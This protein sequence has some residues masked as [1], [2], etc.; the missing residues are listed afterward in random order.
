M[1]EPRYLP[2]GFTVTANTVYVPLGVRFARGDVRGG[3]KEER[4][5]EESG[6]Q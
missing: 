3:E 1:L 5:R 2:Y 6:E 4:G